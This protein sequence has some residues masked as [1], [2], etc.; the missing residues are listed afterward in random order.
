MKILWISNFPMSAEQLSALGD[1]TVTTIS[2][3]DVNDL[4]SL[5]ER[6]KGFDIL[7]TQSILFLPTGV[8]LEEDLTKELESVTIIM[9]TNTRTYIEGQGKEPAKFV[10]QF[11]GW[12]VLK[13]GKVLP[14]LH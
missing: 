8:L 2:E 10:F 1:C 4:D 3:G 6:V 14:P 5:K 12:K 11:A 7:A 9:P 13:K